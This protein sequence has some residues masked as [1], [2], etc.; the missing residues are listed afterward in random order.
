[1]ERVGWMG[2]GR[3]LECILLGKKVDRVRE[4]D[5]LRGLKD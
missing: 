5:L 2:R 4:E 3:G 1:M